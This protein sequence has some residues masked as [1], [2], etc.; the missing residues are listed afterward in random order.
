MIDP[1]ALLVLTDDATV[2]TPAGECSAERI[3]VDEV[4]EHDPNTVQVR[5]RAT[6][7]L[8]ATADVEQC[9]DVTDL[10]FRPVDLDTLVEN[11]I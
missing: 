2:T 4:R 3:A 7:L 10:A 6:S 11:E 9:I 8:I 5:T 1:I